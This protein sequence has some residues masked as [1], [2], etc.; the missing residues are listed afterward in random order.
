MIFL[1]IS[2][3]IPDCCRGRLPER[4][5]EGMFFFLSTLSQ[6]FGFTTPCVSRGGP[7]EISRRASWV[8]PETDVGSTKQMCSYE[9]WAPHTN[10]S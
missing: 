3:V 10:F 7:P 5:I 6:N 1:L 8:V 9:V 2:I 4:E